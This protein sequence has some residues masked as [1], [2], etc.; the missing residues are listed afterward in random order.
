MVSQKVQVDH[1]FLQLIEIS[2]IASTAVKPSRSV[3][4]RPKGISLACLVNEGRF[5]CSSVRN[6]RKKAPM[7]S[8]KR[9]QE[10]R[11]FCLGQCSIEHRLLSWTNKQPTRPHALRNIDFRPPATPC[12]IARGLAAE[13]LNGG[14]ASKS[15]F[16]ALPIS[17]KSRH[18]LLAKT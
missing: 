14:Q 3:E 4:P 15:E 9:F 2:E 8:N 18:K 6:H 11:A 13:A 17:I 1:P 12:R 10:V 16:L 5:V 7:F